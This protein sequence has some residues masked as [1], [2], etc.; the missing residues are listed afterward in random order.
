MLFELS[1]F[2]VIYETFRVCYTSNGNCK[3]LTR[4]LRDIYKYWDFKSLRRKF[5]NTF[6]FPDIQE[7]TLVVQYTRQSTKICPI[8][9][10]IAGI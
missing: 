1:I 2:P 4:K 10:S 3:N 5:L 9:G 6:R 7:L 8:Y